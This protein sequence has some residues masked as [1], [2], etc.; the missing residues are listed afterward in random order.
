MSKPSIFFLLT[1]AILLVTS[2]TQGKPEIHSCILKLLRVEGKAGTFAE[3]L[4]VFAFFDDTDGAADFGSITVTN[5]ESG[6]AWKIVPEN[7][8]VRLVGKDRWT[9]SNDLASPGDDLFS[10]GT[11]SVTVSD[12]AGNETSGDYTLVRPKFPER[13]PYRFTVNGDAWR[14]ERNGVDTDFN[15]I[16]LFLYD[17]NNQLLNSWKVPEMKN[18][19]LDGSVKT[20]LLTAKNAVSAQCYFEND[21]GTAGVLLIPVNLQ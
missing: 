17:R 21:S 14:L 2:C 19:V 12:L 15:R 5:K 20:L 13:S 8:S 16:W 18:A 1:C 3:R 4:S 10:G 7:C 9:G 11:Y 6:L